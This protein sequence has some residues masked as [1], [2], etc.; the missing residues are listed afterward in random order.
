MGNN[1]LGLVTSQ[2]YVHNDSTMI[3]TLLWSSIIHVYINGDIPYLKIGSPDLQYVP[4][5]GIIIP[6]NKT[7]CNKQAL[8]DIHW[9]V[10]VGTMHRDCS[11]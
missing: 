10:L 9:N 6:T 7:Q 11:L 2:Y 4:N 8:F 5:P 1:E 3:P